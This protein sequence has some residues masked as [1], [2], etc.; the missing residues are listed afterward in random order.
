[1]PTSLTSRSPTTTAVFAPRKTSKYFARIVL[2]NK[3][4]LLLFVFLDGKG[5][6]V[7]EKEGA[8]GSNIALSGKGMRWRCVALCGVERKRSKC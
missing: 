3:D 7:D 6:L 1:M 8:M 5:G 4:I 2:Q